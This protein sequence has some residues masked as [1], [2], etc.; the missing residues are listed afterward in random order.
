MTHADL[1]ERAAKWLKNYFHCRVPISEHVACTDTGETP[2]AI[3]WVFNKCILIECKASISDFHADKR[4]RARR[5]SYPALGHWRFYL[6]PPGLLAKSEII[7]GW[8]VYEVH[9]RRVIHTKGIEYQN[10]S[11]APFV[12]CRDS[13]V[14]I[15]LSYISK[16]EFYDYT[17]TK[18]E[19]DPRCKNNNLNPGCFNCGC[20]DEKEI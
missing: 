3:G 2:D 5:R 4:K 13:E 10:A 14:A 9:G 7:N 8:G 12:S 6:T 19:C 16:K 20:L 1:V 11:R 17:S 18:D 15:L